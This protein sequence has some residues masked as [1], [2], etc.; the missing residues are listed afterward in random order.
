MELIR[1]SARLTRCRGLSS[2][3]PDAVARTVSDTDVGRAG[4][5]GGVRD[6][7]RPEIGA[8]CQNSGRYRSSVA[9][10]RR[11]SFA[12]R[13]DQTIHDVSEDS[14]MIADMRWT[15]EGLTAR[16]FS[17]FVPFAALPSSDVPAGPGVYVVVRPN[18]SAPLFLPMN[19]AGRF[20]GKDPSVTV[21]ALE[22]SWVAGVSLVYV[23]K[24]NGGGNGKRGIRK[25]LDEYRRHGAGEP[26]GHWGGRYIW[27]LAD[28]A[29]LLVG[30]M[31]TQDEEARIVE[32]DMI[33]EFTTEHLK[34]PFA[35]LKD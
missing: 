28:S 18:E 30:W 17:G 15:Q 6:P 22:E 8:R 31:Q 32:R 33:A 10:R 35:N 25:R 24:A 13:S 4:R 23:G 20:K 2:F 29:E 19:P 3:Q 26:V 7:I 27:Q 12:D 21:E 11:G 34:R 1:C 14:G 9:W 16:G 5:I